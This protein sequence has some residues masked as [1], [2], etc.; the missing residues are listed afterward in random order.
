MLK[1]VAQRAAQ[2]GVKRHGK[3]ALGL[4]IKILR[5]KR[6]AYINQNAL[7]AQSPVSVWRQRDVDYLWRVKF[8]FIRKRKGNISQNRVKEGDSHFQRVRHGNSVNIPQELVV[9]IT[10]QAECAYAL[11]HRLI[12]Q[13]INLLKVKMFSNAKIGSSLQFGRKYRR[14]SKRSINL[15][16]QGV[17]LQEACA[18]P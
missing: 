7:C 8:A 17:A 14:R 12:C 13:L 6:A 18:H 15:L 9:S 2:P 5:E 10:T 3:A 11:K 4:Y 1:Y 16:L